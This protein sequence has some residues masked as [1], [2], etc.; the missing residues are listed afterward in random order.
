MPHTPRQPR[1]RD[2][3][4]DWLFDS[5]RAIVVRMAYTGRRRVATRVQRDEVLRLIGQGASRRDTARR[6]FGDDR[7]KGRVDRIIRENELE[8][9]RGARRRPRTSERPLE[10]GAD[11]GDI[12]Q[13]EELFESYARAL[14]AR[15]EDPDERVTAGEL[16][17]FARLEHWVENKR[18]LAELKALTR[19]PPRPPSDHD[20]DGA[21]PGPH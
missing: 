6:V 15:L 11:Q 13:L 8:T 16:L 5:F 10:A 12:P 1:P 4:L 9:A 2:R 20:E 21:S 17:A 14:R 18:T 19:E 3:E 7:L